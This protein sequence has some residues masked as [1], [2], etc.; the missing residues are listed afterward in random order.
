VDDPALAV[1]DGDLVSGD[2][3]G[4]WSRRLLQLRGGARPRVPGRAVREQGRGTDEEAGP[5]LA[6]PQ[7]RSSPRPDASPA[8]SNAHGLPSSACTQSVF[9]EDSGVH[10]V[11][12]EGV[13][14]GDRLGLWGGRV[15]TMVTEL[16]S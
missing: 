8:G 15:L 10:P 12:W 11:S 13:A 1:V 4:G 14:N 3:S 5:P 2:G 9:F 16:V 6:P 7:A